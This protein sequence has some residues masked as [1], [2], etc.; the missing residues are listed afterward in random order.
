MFGLQKVYEDETLKALSPEKLGLDL[1]ENR[2]NEMDLYL[3]SVVVIFQILQIE[4]S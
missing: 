3:T 2:L 4:T 1:L